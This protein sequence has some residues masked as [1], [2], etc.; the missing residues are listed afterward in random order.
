[1]AVLDRK[2][3]TF[4]N[5][6][7]SYDER[8]SH[9]KFEASSSPHLSSLARSRESDLWARTQAKKFAPARAQKLKQTSR[10]ILTYV[11][12]SER[13]LFQPNIRMKFAL[14]V[15]YLPLP[16]GLGLLYY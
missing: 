16:V 4:L 5:F 1:M 8:S 14:R 9:S 10:Y 6:S 11:S 12:R 13:A 3:V 15:H 2:D 7:L